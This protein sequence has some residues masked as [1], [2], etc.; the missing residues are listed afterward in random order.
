MKWFTEMI[1]GIIHLQ[2]NSR[3]NNEN[4]AFV[5]KAST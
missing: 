3:Y 1:V 2:M 5:N 4:S